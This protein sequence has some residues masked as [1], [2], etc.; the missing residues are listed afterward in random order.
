MTY[1]EQIEHFVQ[2]RW[3]IEERGE[4][5]VLVAKGE[6]LKHW[7]HIILCLATAGIWGF[8]YGP[9]WRLVD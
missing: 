4:G 2:K 1:E 5:W 9:C 7:A 6:K 3:R 8:V